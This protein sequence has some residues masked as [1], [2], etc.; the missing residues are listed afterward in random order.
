MNRSLTFLAIGLMALVAS[1][2]G[3]SLFSKSTVEQDLQKAAAEEGLAQPTAEA[4]IDQE[5]KNLDTKIQD[6]SK[7][8]ATVEKPAPTKPSMFDQAKG[9]AMAAAASIDWSD[10]SWDKISEIPYDDKAQLLAWAGSQ[11]DTWKGKLGQMALQQG[12]Q[13]L[14]KLGDAGWQGALKNVVSALDQVRKSNPET[15]EMARGALVSAWDKF[16]VEAGKYMGEL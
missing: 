16:E 7:A 5:L 6:E 8:A 14:S 10:I 11:V 12:T 2:Q 9:A 3:E 1:L 4:K 13:G 15:W